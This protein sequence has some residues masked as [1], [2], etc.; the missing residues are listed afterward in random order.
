VIEVEPVVIREKHVPVEV[1]LW[2]Q[3]PNFLAVINDERDVKFLEPYVGRTVTLKIENI[4]VSGT[5]I[6]VRHGR[7]HELEV[8]LPKRL[9]TTW[10]M[11]RHRSIKHDAVVIIRLEGDELYGVVE[12]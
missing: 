6:K 10:E 7:K 3:D 5:L 2:K 9:K 11:L 4:Y 12:P 1:R 8:V